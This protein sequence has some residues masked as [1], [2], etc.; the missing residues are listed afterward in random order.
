[1]CILYAYPSLCFSSDFF[2]LFISSINLAC[3]GICILNSLAPLLSALN[4]LK[5]SRFRVD[6]EAADGD[7]ARNEGMR[8]YRL[9]GFA[10]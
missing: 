4:L 10:H 5:A 1:M 9:H 8:L 2:T 6:D 7:A 3:V